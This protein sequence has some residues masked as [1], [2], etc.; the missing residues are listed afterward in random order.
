MPAAPNWIS[1]GWE[2]G[3]PPFTNSVSALT[4][5]TARLDW[6][7]VIG[8]TYRVYW[9]FAPFTGSYVPP[10]GPIE[11]FTVP[12]PANSSF[13][14]KS[15]IHGPTSLCFAVTSVDASGN[16]SAF[17]SIQNMWITG[18]GGG[19]SRSPLPFGPNPRGCG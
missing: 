7:D 4:A 15:G 10:T 2:S 17:S 18:A 13:L 14:Q 1:V 9:C 12:N 5:D 8:C 11:F 16:E 3:G 19:M 6:W